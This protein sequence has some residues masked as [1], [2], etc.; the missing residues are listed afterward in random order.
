[1][2]AKPIEVL[3]SMNNDQIEKITEA[4]V[5]GYRLGNA[6]GDDIL[7]N[8][9]ELRALIKA[10]FNTTILGDRKKYPILN[11]NFLASIGGLRSWW[12]KR[13]SISERYVESYKLNFIS[14]YSFNLSENNKE[15]LLLLNKIIPSSINYE[16]D[17]GIDRSVLDIIGRIK[18]D[19][20]KRALYEEATT[21]T[22][23]NGVSPFIERDFFYLA[24]ILYPDLL[25]KM[26]LNAFSGWYSML[27]IDI[28]NLGLTERHEE[29]L[30]L[31]TTVGDEVVLNED[32]E[33]RSKVLC[34]GNEFNL[35]N[36]VLE[37][38]DSN[39]NLEY[40]FRHG[41]YI[42]G[43]DIEEVKETT[44]EEFIKFKEEG[45]INENKGEKE[46]ENNKEVKEEIKVEE[47]T[48][49]KNEG[50]FSKPWVKNTLIGIGVLLGGAA[51]AAAYN[52]IKDEL[53]EE[54]LLEE[55]VFLPDAD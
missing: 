3:A 7:N 49:E 17:D 53:Q 48:T 42:V 14:R 19:S 11:R 36:V 51:G 37:M 5:E 54:S 26:D 22:I 55:I 43:D 39:P 45:T 34:C 12:D 40:L 38:L 27:L 47:I 50:F 32:P 1:M 18:N 41:N 44:D 10:R 33:V 28:K 24:L 35:E 6:I 21:Y 2:C 13:S 29:F 31:F 15:E 23:Q 30:S 4:L 8:E 46:M 20:L 16:E 52:Y 9:K 25:S